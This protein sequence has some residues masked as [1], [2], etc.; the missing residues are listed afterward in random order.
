M[1]KPK[2]KGHQTYEKDTEAYKKIITTFG[3]EILD[4]NKLIDRKK[5]GA[6]V[7]NNKE[8]LK[9]LTDV[10]WPEIQNLVTEN[11]AALFSQGHKIIVVEAALLIDANWNEGMNEVWVCFVPDEE[12]ISRSVVRDGS[13]AER[14]QGI[15]NSQMKNKDRIARANVVLCSLWEREYTVKQVHKAWKSL[16]ERTINSKL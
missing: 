6:K 5:L 2:I 8:E 1:I 15:L 3:E 12:A 7:F 16:Q 14:I 13:N 10:V 4:E 11:I 9:K